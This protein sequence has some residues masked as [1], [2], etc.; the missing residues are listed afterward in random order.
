MKFRIEMILPDSCDPSS[1]L[2]RM[3]EAAVE[4]TE[5]E[6]GYELP[7]TRRESVR[8]TVSVQVMP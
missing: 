1:L 2:E 8:E 6:R 5:E 4:I 3:Q 7:E